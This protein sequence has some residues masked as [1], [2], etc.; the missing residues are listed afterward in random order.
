MNRGADAER[1]RVK[2]ITDMGKQYGRT[3][4]AM[5]HIADGKTPEG[6]HT[7]V[8]EKL[9]AMGFEIYSTSGTATVLYQVNQKV[10]FS[11]TK[12]TDLPGSVA[13]AC[14]AFY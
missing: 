13:Q 6:P 9:V 8:R 11:M 4:M 7:H 14:S 12:A 2:S 1:A 3:D 5:Q 10:W